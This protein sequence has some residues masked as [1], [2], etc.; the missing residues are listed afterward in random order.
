MWPRLWAVHLVY[1]RDQGQPTQLHT[2]A[3]R[4]AA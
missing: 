1:L 2:D 4:V 3:A